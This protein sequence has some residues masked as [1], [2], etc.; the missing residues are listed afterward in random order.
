MITAGPCHAPHTAYIDQL[1][2]NLQLIKAYIC[3]DITRFWGANQSAMPPFLRILPA[4]LGALFFGSSALQRPKDLRPMFGAIGHSLTCDVAR[5]L[6]HDDVWAVVQDI[7]PAGFNFSRA[8]TWADEIRWHPGEKW[9]EPFHYIDTE[10][11][12]P[13]SCSFD[14]ARDCPR[15]RGCIVSAMLNY[16]DRLVHRKRLGRPAAEE[17]LKMLVHLIGDVHQPL[18]AAGRDFGGTRF[19]T[20]FANRATT[21][22][23]VWD[24]LMIEKRIKDDFDYSIPQFFSHLLHGVLPTVDPAPCRGQHAIGLFNQQVEVCPEEWAAQTNRLGCTGLVW[25]ADHEQDLAGDY[26]ANAIQEQERQI[27]TAGIRI[28]AALTSILGKGN[29][30]NSRIVLQKSS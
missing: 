23:T 14:Y 11:D 4:L 20:R 2:T 19:A 10:D 8:C 30:T 12:Q 29:N 6:L 21:L 7:L 25:P 28:A 22:H 13:N 26:Y 18:H 16:T 27:V 1:T 5:A 24:S 9:R 17:A 15:D 3:P